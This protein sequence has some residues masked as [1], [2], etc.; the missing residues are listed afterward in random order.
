MSL[1]SVLLVGDFNA[2]TGTNTDF[3]DCSQLVNV[4]LVP[5]TIEDTLPNNMLKRQNHDIVMAG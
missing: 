2:R 1:G 3:I 4:L 5:Q